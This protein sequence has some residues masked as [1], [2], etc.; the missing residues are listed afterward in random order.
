[1]SNI[2]STS[3]NILVAMWMDGVFGQE[4]LD[5]IHEELAVRRLSWRIRFVDSPDAF[6]TTARWMHRLRLL[7]GVI[8]FYHESPV[9]KAIARAHIPNVRLCRDWFFDRKPTRRVGTAFVMPDRAEIAQKAVGHLLSRATFRSAGYVENYWDRGWSRQR[10]DAVMAEFERCGMQ[11]ERFLHRGV[12]SP[13]HSAAGPD[14]AALA[15]WLRAL[16]KPAALVAANDATAADVVQV[17]ETTGLAV[18]RDVAVLGMDDNPIICQ[19]CEPNLSSVHFDGYRAGRLCAGALADLLA[20]AEPPPAPLLYGVARIPPRGSTAT[21]SAAGQLVQGALDYIDAHACHGATLADVVRHL[22]VSRTLVTLRF[23]Q[24][25]GQSVE[26]AIRER[27]F[28][29]VR[30]LLRDTN[31]PAEKIAAQCGYES[32]RALRRAF[33]RETGQ[34]LSDWRASQQ[35]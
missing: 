5:G 21:P 35:G 23:R 30:R 34:S 28:G 20:G 27:R 18:P 11:P 3:P 7:D 31:L 2:A 32:A 15:K 19:H 24:L 14:F 26:Q 6:L 22:G 13:D 1:M 9:M 16:E 8:T 29:E 17:C 10:G 25:R 4:V 33:Q 12:T